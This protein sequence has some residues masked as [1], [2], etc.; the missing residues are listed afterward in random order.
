MRPSL[1]CS[2]GSAATDCRGEEGDEEPAQLLGWPSVREGE[3]G[4]KADDSGTRAITRI[5]DADECREQAPDERVVAR[6]AGRH[7][8]HVEEQGSRHASQLDQTRDAACARVRRERRD[9]VHPYD[10]DAC[11]SRSDRLHDE[12]QERRDASK[13][14][15]LPRRIGLR[16]PV[17][18]AVQR[19]PVVELRQ[20]EDI[21]SGVFEAIAPADVRCDGR[22]GTQVRVG[23]DRQAEVL[24]DIR[25]QRTPYLSRQVVVRR[26]FPWQ[27]L[28]PKFGEVGIELLELVSVV[29]TGDGAHVDEDV[30]WQ[31]P[32]DSAVEFLCSSRRRAGR[33]CA[34]ARMEDGDND[35][36]LVQQLS[37]D[38]FLAVAA[39]QLRHRVQF[40]AGHLQPNA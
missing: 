38:H 27:A 6:G 35:V 11:V 24:R 12:P 29:V 37:A 39:S 34:E 10:V 4:P 36:R 31:V 7:P 8:A 2:L 28:L 17:A 19:L 3:L 33:G 20:V 18:R 9:Q 13:D 22:P 32:L 40:P 25:V 21:V 16:E 1:P 15:F 14:G 30:Y 23:V 5:V 26:D